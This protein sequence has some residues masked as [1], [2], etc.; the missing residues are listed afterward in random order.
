[1][2][3]S[4][5]AADGGAR[6]LKPSELRRC[7]TPPCGY[8]SVHEHDITLDNL[9]NQPLHVVLE[10]ARRLDLHPGDLTPCA[11]QVYDHPRYFDGP[12]PE[13]AAK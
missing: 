2:P 7:G 10:L 6:A 11:A 1:M 3:A 13:A 5:G 4:F 9:P 8:G 12:S